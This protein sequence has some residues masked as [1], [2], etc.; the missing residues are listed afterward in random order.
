MRLFLKEEKGWTIAPFD[1]SG[2]KEIIYH[3]K[4]KKYPFL[5]VH[6]CT[7]IKQDD[8]QS[9]AV[10]KDAIRCFAVNSNTK[11]GWI[12]TSRVYRTTGWKNNLFNKV[13]EVI[14]AAEKRMKDY[15]NEQTLRTFDRQKNQYNN[16]KIYPGKPQWNNKPANNLDMERAAERE[17]YEIESEMD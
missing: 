2:T 17:V 5:V 6:V 9:R 4:L 12:S 10:G 14:A 16:S 3:Y 7:G 15:E 8:E 1:L 13:K 11:R